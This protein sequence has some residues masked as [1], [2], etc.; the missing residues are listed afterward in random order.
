MTQWLYQPLQLHTVSLML[1]GLLVTAV[2]LYVVLWSLWRQNKAALGWFGALSTVCAV[3]ALFYLVQYEK[4]EWRQQLYTLVSLQM[5]LGP[6]LYFF[7]LKMVMP[8]QPLPRLWWLHLLPAMCLALLWWLQWPA[9][10]SNPSLWSCI[11]DFSCNQSY[12][13]RWLHRLSAWLSI[14]FYSGISLQQLRRHRQRLMQQHSDLDRIQL[15]WLRLLC[16]VFIAAVLLSF[17]SELLVLAGF[18]LY[19]S[20]AGIQALAPLLSVFMLSYFG[21]RQ[22]PLQLNTQSG[23]GLTE[24]AAN[25]Q[26]APSPERKYQTSSLTRQA[27]EQLWHEL[28]EFMHSQKPYLEAG[29]KIAELAQQLD[30]TPHHVSETI[31]GHAGLSFYDFINNYRVDE[32][33]RLLLN[34]KYDHWSVTDVGFQSGFNSNSTFFAQFK[35]RMRQTPRQFREQRQQV[36]ASCDFAKPE[37]QRWPQS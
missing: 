19:I 17:G 28:T 20:G 36:A 18:P 2:M 6:M 15:Q 24:T 9:P 7:T 3:L 16:Q 25:V 4:P 1:M 35:K 10:Y 31:N 32:A 34:K 27:A 23:V 12:A 26:P 11:E 22:L 37:D 30:Q 8:A 5:W 21:L 13:D 29:L 14:G 33:A